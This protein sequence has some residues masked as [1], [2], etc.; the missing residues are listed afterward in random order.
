MSEDDYIDTP[1]Q[2]KKKGNRTAIMGESYA[3]NNFVPKVL[4]KSEEQ[5]ANIRSKLT[6]FLFSSLT[7]NEIAIIVDAMDEVTYK[8]NERVIK[9][10]DPGNCLYIVASGKLKCSKYMVII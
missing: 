3:D 4:Q 2:P 8:P 9:Q 1:A 6:S 5:K 7:E 10:G